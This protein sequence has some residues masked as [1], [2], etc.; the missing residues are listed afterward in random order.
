M[1]ALM[2]QHA[3][4][5]VENV[6][7]RIGENNIRSQKAAEKIGATRIGLRQDRYGIDRVLYRIT[8]SMAGEKITVPAFDALTVP[9]NSSQPTNNF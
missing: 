9:A 4:K 1:K 5:F 6:V 7:F 2:L 3:F 8:Y